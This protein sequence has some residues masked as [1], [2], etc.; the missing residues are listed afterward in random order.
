MTHSRSSLLAA[1]AALALAG[2]SS[3]AG[4]RS[5]SGQLTAGA[6]SL[7]NAVVIARSA[8]G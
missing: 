8:A 3:S 5:V 4:T 1:A 2:C 7:D 6:Y